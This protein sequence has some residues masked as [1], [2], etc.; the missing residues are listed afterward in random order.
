LLEIEND[1][2]HLDCISEKDVGM[3][4]GFFLRYHFNSTSQ[5][6][7]SF[8]YGNKIKKKYQKSIIISNNFKKGG[9]GGLITIFKFC[10]Q[11]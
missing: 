6:C 10:Y 1:S 3:C 7:E 2:E 9:C 4:R 11:V 8:Y 5:K